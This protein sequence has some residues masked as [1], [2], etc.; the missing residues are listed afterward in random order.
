MPGHPFNWVHFLPNAP[1]EVCEWVKSK[2]IYSQ[3]TNW[4]QETLQIIDQNSDN[5]DK[6]ICTTTLHKSFTK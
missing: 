4:N 1:E 3:W 5:S 2:G 6:N